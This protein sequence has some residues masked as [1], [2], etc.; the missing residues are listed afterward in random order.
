MKKQR[1]LTPFLLAMINVSAIC[2]IRNWPVAATYGFSSLFLI[3]LVSIVFFVPIAFVSAEL[4]TGWPESGGVFAWVKEAFGHEMGFLSVWFLWLTNIP[5]YPTLLAFI[6]GTLAFIFDPKLANDP[7]YT[8]SMILLLFWAATFL[9]LKGMK[10]SSWIS[11]FGVICGTLLPGIVII[12]LGISWIFLENPIQIELSTKA[13]FPSIRGI[14][15]LVLITGI[16]FSFAGIEMS[17]VHAKEVVNPQKTYP[18]AIF[19]SVLIIFFVTALGTL[20]IAIVIPEKE[21]SLVSGVLDTVSYFF[22]AYG[23]S[24]GIPFIAG[25]IAIGAFG[26]MSTWIAGPSKGLLAAAKYGDL[27][28]FLKRVNKNA[29]PSALMVF[30]GI[31]VSFLALVFLFM[32]SVSSSFWLLTAMTAQF[33]LLM[34]LLMFSAA[35][36]LKFQKPDVPRSFTVPG[37]KI[38]MCL[39]SGVGIFVSFFAFILGF[40]PPE[41]FEMGNPYFYTLFLLSGVSLGVFLPMLP[42]LVRKFQRSYK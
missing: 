2:S 27:P 29:M 15:Q 22:K 42:I 19:L 16:L 38:G 3:I 12:L 39:I 7:I 25:S 36:Y 37:G 6:S 11:S 18:K 33:Y 5:W 17:A 30:Q 10:T 1:I 21:I 14:N 23:L 13:F 28:S 41:D 26:Q 9:N 32:P 35:I 31:V 24:K 40:I 20:S 34:Y 4:A 8:L